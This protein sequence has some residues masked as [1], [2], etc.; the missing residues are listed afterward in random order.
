MIQPTHEKTRAVIG[1][2]LASAISRPNSSDICHASPSQDQAK[3]E[4]KRGKSQA[5]G[6]AAVP[7]SRPRARGA[8]NLLWI[9]AADQFP[10]LSVQI[11]PKLAA[12]RLHKWRKAADVGTR[13]DMLRARPRPAMMKGTGHGQ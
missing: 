7:R 1:Y 8:R 11:R 10:G 3:G 2:P 12:D 9:N 4:G 5:I 6:R 13:D